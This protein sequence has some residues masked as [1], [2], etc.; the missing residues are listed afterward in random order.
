MCEYTPPE[1]LRLLVYAL[2][3][4]VSTLHRLYVLVFYAIGRWQVNTRSSLFQANFAI[5]KNS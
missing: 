3:R 4:M 1:C 5:S 2:N